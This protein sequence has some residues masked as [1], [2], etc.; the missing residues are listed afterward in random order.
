MALKR[1]YLFLYLAI[2]C[3][4]GLVAIFIVDAY[5]G[6]YDTLYITTGEYEQKVEADWWMRE[7]TFWSTG[8]RWGEK[9]SF[10]YEIEN[11][12]F[13]TYSTHIQASVWKE[14][15]KVIGLLSEDKSIG[16]FDKVTAE[17]T[18][19]SEELE[20]AGFG[21]DGYADYTVKISYGDVER[22]IIVN[23]YY[24]EGSEYP[25]P[26]PVPAPGR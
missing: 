12:Q 26:K 19:S 22:R 1:R 20:S 4:A 15:E 13:S 5:L 6:I 11:H 18:L 9:V 16:P 14:N 23:F 3:I 7:E 25:V 24:P 8:A 2:A 17:W 10:R 21:V